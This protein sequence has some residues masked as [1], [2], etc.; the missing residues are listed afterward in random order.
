[1]LTRERAYWEAKLIQIQAQNAYLERARLVADVETAKLTAYKTQAEA[2]TAQ[3]NAITSQ[4]LFANAKMAAVTTAVCVVFFSIWDAV[5]IA[6]GIFFKGDNE[7]L[8]GLE[9]FHEYPIEEAFFLTLL[10][11]TGQ[12]VMAAWT[13]YSKAGAK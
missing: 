10:A 5:G 12:I 2:Y 9:V 7:L 6:N 1:V 13:R 3:V 11:Y 8:I 4:V